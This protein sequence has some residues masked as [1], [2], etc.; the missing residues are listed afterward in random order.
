M[1]SEVFFLSTGQETIELQEGQ[2]RSKDRAAFALFLF[3]GLSQQF[4]SHSWIKAT[5]ISRGVRVIAGSFR[6]P[7]RRYGLRRLLI[8]GKVANT[9]GGLHRESNDSEDRKM[10]LIFYGVTGP[11]W[12]WAQDL[13]SKTAHAS[14]MIRLPG[15]RQH[16]HVVARRHVGEVVTMLSRNVTFVEILVRSWDDIKH[17]KTYWR[18]E[19]KIQL[20]SSWNQRIQGDLWLFHGPWSGQ[21]TVRL[22]SVVALGTIWLCGP[23]RRSNLN[24]KEWKDNLSR[25]EDCWLHRCQ[26]PNMLHLYIYI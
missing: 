25:S 5:H 15:G 13:R 20:K 11:M 23:Q 6:F 26:L 12:F 1:V 22:E 4:S 16:T 18:S 19:S 24:W 2:W 8:W 10:F 17:H 21:L 3:L 7:S 14:L 9:L